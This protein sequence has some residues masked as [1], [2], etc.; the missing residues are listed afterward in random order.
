L[1]STTNCKSIMG[2]KFG[3][4]SFYTAKLR[5]FVVRKSDADFLSGER[6]NE[7]HHS[8]EGNL[9][10]NEKQKFRKILGGASEG[11]KK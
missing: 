6:Q 1:Y 8:S 9:L 10:K 5:M 3:K 2:P 4:N 11:K 7:E